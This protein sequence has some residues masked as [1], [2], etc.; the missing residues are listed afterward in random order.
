MEG[1]VLACVNR[2]LPVEMFIA[3]P[4]N[5]NTSLRDAAQA[6][7]AG[8]GI[9]ELGPTPQIIRMAVPL[10]LRSVRPPDVKRFPTKYR[11][12]VKQALQL[13]KESDPPKGTLAVYQE[14]EDLTRSLA[15]LAD[16]KGA[17]KGGSPAPL[18][19]DKDPWQ[20]ITELLMKH[21]TT[22]KSDVRKSPCR[23]L[24]AW[25]GFATTETKSAT[26]QRRWLKD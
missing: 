9:A 22:I 23:C 19:W 24:A 1:F 2:G 26:S 11:G 16:S 3:Y 13:F 15:Q 4:P 6:I 12:A 14:I 5:G 8:L 21:S 10:R 17:W 18:R 20:N 25:L 7:E